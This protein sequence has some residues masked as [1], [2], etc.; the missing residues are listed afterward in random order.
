M[1]LANTGMKA[2]AVSGRLLNSRP[3]NTPAKNIVSR[4]RLVGS[5]I[6]NSTAMM[7]K[8]AVLWDMKLLAVIRKKGDEKSRTAASSPTPTP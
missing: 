4:R 5:V 3:R 6:R 2:T 7:V 1:K 8:A